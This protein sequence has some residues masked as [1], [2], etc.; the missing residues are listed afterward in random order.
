MSLQTNRECHLPPDVSQAGETKTNRELPFISRL[1]ASPC[2]PLHIYSTLPHSW[3]QTI[4]GYRKLFNA[5]L[6]RT[7]GSWFMPRTNFSGVN[8]PFEGGGF[9]AV[10][11]VHI[12]VRLLR[13]HLHKWT[14][15]GEKQTRVQFKQTKLH[16]C[17]NTLRLTYSLVQL[18]AV[19]MKETGSGPEVLSGVLEIISGLFCLYFWTCSFWPSP[20]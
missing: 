12:R 20:L 11:L 2:I 17:K 6:Q 7:S 1:V 13:S 16:R 5:N 15:L 4:R 3:I 14:P 9:G 10:V 19:W 18:V 8:R